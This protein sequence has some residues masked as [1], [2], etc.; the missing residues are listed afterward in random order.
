M[1]L[2]TL[3]GLF[4]FAAFSAQLVAQEPSQETTVSIAAPEARQYAKPVSLKEP[5][6]TNAE[7]SG[8]VKAPSQEPHQKMEWKSDE[9][10]RRLS[11]SAQG[12]APSLPA[13]KAGPT[14]GPAAWRLLVA[15]GVMALLIYGLY[16]FLKKFGRKLKGDEG[17][18]LKLVSSLKVDS[19]NSLA[20][21][22][23]H[24]EELLLAVNS[25]GGVQLLSKCAQID[26]AEAE[27]GAGLGGADEGYDFGEGVKTAKEG[28]E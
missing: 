26:L 20:L 24:E 7:E 17:E 8:S 28:L 3:V 19:R 13:R 16:L 10:K 5:V 18:G 2:K 1:K 14:E 15:F 22:R 23:F 6:Q 11:G 9:A 4:F 27:A 12:A 25:S 21:I